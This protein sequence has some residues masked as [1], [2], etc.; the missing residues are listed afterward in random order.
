[1]FGD[2][3]DFSRLVNA[4]INVAGCFENVYELLIIV[5]VGEFLDCPSDYQFQNKASD[6]CFN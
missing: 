4:A 3:L 1:M 5:N 2:S 6:V